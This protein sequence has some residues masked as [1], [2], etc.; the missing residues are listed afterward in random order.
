M[1]HLH[2]WCQLEAQQQM[3]QRGGTVEPV[4]DELLRQTKS[5]ADTLHDRAPRSRLPAGL[6]EHTAQR[7]GRSRARSANAASRL[8]ARPPG[9]P[10]T[11]GRI[12]AAARVLPV[13]GRRSSRGSGV[14]T[15]WP[16]IGPPLAS[17]MLMAL[18]ICG[19]ELP[20]STAQRPGTGRPPANCGP[21]PVRCRPR[22]PGPAGRQAHCATVAPTA[23][24]R[25][26][27]SRSEPG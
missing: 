11:G 20:R 16:W 23:P 7:Q 15:P 12:V 21:T 9:T 24:P 14:A 5:P 26:A 27:N 8:V 13:P 19:S 2:V 10:A 4:P 17:L 1:G 22:N 18:R 6:V 3:H 25:G